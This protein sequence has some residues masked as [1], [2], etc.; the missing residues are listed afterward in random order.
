MTILRSPIRSTTR[1]PLR[2]T[3]ESAFGG[4]SN[5]LSISAP[6][7]SILTADQPYDFSAANGN[8][9]TATDSDAGGGDF[10][11][12][13]S[14]TGDGTPTLTLAGTTGLVFA[15]G[16][17]TADAN[18]T[19]DCT[20]AEFN[21]AVD[22]ATL[23]GGSDGSA[24]IAYSMT[25]GTNTTNA[26]QTVQ[27][28]AALA[29]DTF[30]PADNAVGVLYDRS[31]FTATFSRAIQVGTGNVVLKLVGGAAL[32]T[33]N[34]ATGSGDQGGSVSISGSDLIVAP[35][36]N[37]TD[38]TAH[39]IQIAATAIDG[40]VLGTSD[41]FAGIADDTTWSF[42]CENTTPTLSAALDSATGGTTGTAAVSTNRG[43]GQLYVVFTTSAT[44]PS[45]DQIAAGDDHTDSAAAYADDRAVTATGAQAAFNATGLTSETQYFA[46][47]AHASANGAEATPVSADGFTT[48][49]VTAPTVSSF[50]PLDNATGVAVGSTLVATFDENVLFAFPGGGNVI[51]RDNDGGFANL[52]TFTPTSTTAATGSAGG[53][54]AIS[55]AVMTITPGADL[56]FEIEHAVQ[57]Q[58]TAI[59]DTSGNA[60]AG[61][62]DDTTWSFTSGTSVT[63][64]PNSANLA[65][66]IDAAQSDITLSG[67]DV[68]AVSDLSGNGVTTT[69]TTGIL[70]SPDGRGFRQTG[71]AKLSISTGLSLDR[72][73]SAVFIV[74]RRRPLDFGAARAYMYMPDGGSTNRFAMYTPNQAFSTFD[75]GANT[76]DLELGA[77]GIDVLYSSNGPTDQRMGVGPQTMLEGAAM[78]TGTPTGG[79][80]FLWDGTSF[81]NVSTDILAVIAYDRELTLAECEGVVDFCATQY[82]AAA[83]DMDTVMITDG[84]SLSD[85]EQSTDNLDFSWPAQMAHLGSESPKI[86]SVADGGKQVTNDTSA[87]DTVA[88][89]GFFSSFTNRVVVCWLGSND[90]ASGRS[91][92]QVEADI[93]SW[94]SSVRA[95]D[96]GAIIIGCTILTRSD[97]TAGEETIRGAVNTHITGTADFDHTV[98]LA[99]ISNLSDET[100]TTYFDGDEVHLTDA[101]YLEVATAVR[102]ELVTQGYLAT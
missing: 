49:D 88:N 36:V 76:S 75:S 22:G 21:T 57:I 97:L 69:G 65:Y 20:V 71:T 61:I 35:G 70:V 100:N 79:R 60:F 78:P 98:D 39:A 80:L 92:A 29:I 26:N 96:A 95:A 37:L 40:A 41:S 27:L 77:S 4:V 14:V 19:F 99:G 59:E 74:T 23:Q 62:T 66:F 52:E 82:G 15:V 46:H 53:S 72:R 89:L 56:A 25:D 31:S 9:P 54:I 93:D 12:T 63:L 83:S 68:T 38:N 2:G 30:A 6:S 90:I 10:T 8:L 85:G 94:I 73:D 48:D 44:T 47:F 1:S 34:I 11:F 7:F 33:F 101:G 28:F 3:L 51:L 45:H 43:D 58:A 32:E 24:S 67:S 18:M 64:P 42:T 87:T 86:A 13:I 91:E 50:N 55:G 81:P 5:P 84:D 17:G 16:D 102:A